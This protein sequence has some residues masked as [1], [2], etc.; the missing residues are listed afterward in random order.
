M[1]NFKKVNNISG[2]IV[3]LIATITYLVTMEKTASLWDCGEF[4]SAAYK[5]EVVHAPGAPFFLMLGR[6]FSLFASEASQVAV[7]IN[8]M[9]ALSSSF[10]ILFLFW[11]I[12]SFGRKIYFKDEVIE[13]SKLIA[14][15]GAGAVGSL[16]YTFSD[17]FWFSAVE[18]EVYAL[19]SFFTALTFW[20][21]LKWEE[22]ADS[23]HSSKWL[24]LIAY[25]I[26]LSIGVHLLSLLTIPAMGMIYYFKNNKYTHW[27]AV[28][29][30]GVSAAIL[31]VIQGILIPKTASLMGA[32]DR[33][34]VNDFGLP[35]NSGVL[36]FFLLIIG[37]II[38]G[39]VKTRL[40]GN[41]TWN[42]AILGVLVLLIG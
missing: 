39:L 21:I 7:M 19:S 8:S 20:C 32:F 5:L 10:T 25:L 2:W 15:I 36:F 27:G 3:F 37:L 12:T 41:S 4:I 30:L 14:V 9:S 11:T 33:V 28:K 42:T 1:K 22:V 40:A 38:F 29:A 31:L 18:G 23:P 6:I 17:S 13:Q 34:F 26:G 24:V 16:A 35:F